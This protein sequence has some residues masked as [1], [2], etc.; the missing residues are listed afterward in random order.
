[1]RLVSA[2]IAVLFFL[3]VAGASV[4]QSYAA[5]LPEQGIATFYA[6]YLHGNHTASGEI[7]RRE[8]MTC[9]HMTH[10]VGTLLSVTR[11]DNGRRVIV[12]VNDRGVFQQGVIVDLSGAAAIA[13]DM[14]KSGKVWVMVEK[15][16]YSEANPLIPELPRSYDQEHAFTPRGSS[17]SPVM[18]TYSGPHPSAGQGGFGIQLGA[19]GVYENA[20]RAHQHLAALGLGAIRIQ[21]LSA[22]EGLPLFRVLLSSFHTRSDAE[23]YL[24]RYLKAIHLVDGLVIQI[25]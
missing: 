7:Y 3:A 18:P 13:L 5:S 11:V 16:G 14:M 25:R 9:S 10:P 24:E 4:A 19:Y 2:F 20:V 22:S 17:E 1:M 6:D 8:L 12:R 15:V 21:Q 23:I